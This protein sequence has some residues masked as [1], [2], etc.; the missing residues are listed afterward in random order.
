M[1]IAKQIAEE[2]KIKVWQVEAVMELIDEGCTIPFIARYRK[3]KHGSLN[4]EQLRNL[5]ERLT[6][7]RNLEERKETVLASI[8]EQGKLTEELKQQILAAQTQV[9]LEDLY[10]PY[11][12]KRRTRATIAKEKG[13]EILGITEHGPNIPGTC[14]PIYF[15]NLHCVPRQL[16]GIKLMLGAELNILN[17]QGDI[18]LDEDYWRILDIRIAGIHSLCWNGGTKEENTQGVINAM[19]NPFVQIISHP[20]DGTADLDF[21]VL[22]KVSKETHTLLEINNHSMAPIR[23]K[24]VAAPNNLE[25]LELAKKYETP[26]IFGSDAH[27]ST[28]IADYSNI[29]PLVEKAE[30]PDDLVLNYQPEKFL[31]YLKPTPEK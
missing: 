25:L 2:L 26:V 16:Y 10:R 8:E 1:N 23:H 29:M 7:L 11:R 18:D 17:T 24:T 30:F 15:R 19:R 12:P 20:G 22:M 9:L 13:L 28:M 6:Y 14:D 31:A 27:F 3:E 5:D 4:D 21:E